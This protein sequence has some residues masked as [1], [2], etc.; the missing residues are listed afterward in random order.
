[1]LIKIICPLLN[2]GEISFNNGL[3]VILGDDNAKNS[4]GKSSAL[5]VIDFAMGGRSLLDDKAGVIKSMGHHDYIFEF[6]FD[7][8]RYYFKRS[9]NESSVVH[10][11]NINY[12]EVGE[13][14][15]DEYTE[16][17]K[18]LYNLNHLKSSFRSL[19]SPFSR[20][21]NKGALD[22]EQPFS[23]DVKES[24][25]VAIGRLIDF[26]EYT[27][28]IAEEKS[29]LDELNE[30]KKLISKSMNAQIIP[31][32]NKAKYKENQKTITENTDAIKALKQGFTGA[33]SAYEALFDEQLR[34]LQ[35]QKNELASQKNDVLIKIERINRDISG[36]TPRLTANISLIKE[37]LPNVDAKRLEQVESFHQNITKIV[38]RELKRDLDLYSDRLL[39]IN[40]AIIGLENKIRTGLA[41]KGTPDDL[42]MRVFELKEL[43]DKAT[44]ENS[45]YDKKVAFDKDVLLSKERLEA[46]YIGIFLNIEAALNIKLKNFNK[47]VYGP[48]RNASQLRIKNANSYNF[49]S[50]EDTG[51]G[52]SFA[53]LVAFDLA[54]LSLT[55]LPFIIHDSV[56]YKNIEVPATGHI[57]RIL[58]SVKRKQIFLSFD[59]AAKFGAKVEQLLRF[60]TVLKLSDNDLLY[61][62]DWREQQ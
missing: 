14:S 27:E 45:F 11:C 58:A 32:I 55:N 7:D 29:T 31:K 6:I 42:F 18:V 30:K 23:G 17:L 35:Q 56:I 13:I 21:W 48:S 59:E 44:E 54:M 46:I 1:M 49:I 34:K 28:E 25:G 5:M 26:F 20:I 3:N 50:P 62:K 24:A 15:I 16:K 10:V 36:V 38:H 43:V 19:V 12:K 8:I 53:G 40:A 4:I 41:S 47:V 61:T 37:F 33:L 60:H 51:T 22:P 2:H 57:I 52:K 39:E 9:T